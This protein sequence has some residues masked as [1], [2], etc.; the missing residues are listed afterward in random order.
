MIW[1]GVGYLRQEEKTDY[2]FLNTQT[3]FTKSDDFLLILPLFHAKSTLCPPNYAIYDIFSENNQISPSFRGKCEQIL[4]CIS[5]SPWELF[6]AF[7]A[8]SRSTTRCPCSPSH[9]NWICCKK[10]TP[11]C[12]QDAYLRTRCR[13][14]AWR[15]WFRH[16]PQTHC[17]QWFAQR[18]FQNIKKLSS[19][20]SDCI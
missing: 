2:F 4:C 10:L 18:M 5:F 16:H 6:R 7:H 11:A 9:S 19:D 14:W 15:S 20:G 3:S 12:L 13:V 1:H 8:L 17:F